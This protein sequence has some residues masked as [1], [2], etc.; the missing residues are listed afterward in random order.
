MIKD[1]GV[2]KALSERRGPLLHTLP[3]VT[4][5]QYRNILCEKFEIK[6]TQGNNHCMLDDG[7]VVEVLN[8]ATST[9]SNDNVLVGRKY[10]TKSN[11][12]EFPCASS[13][14]EVYK[15]V[16]RSTVTCWDTKRIVCKCIVVPCTD[17]FVCIPVLHTAR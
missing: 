8:I 6:L 5:P 16:G 2:K 15:I 3:G 11:F 7:S 17:F 13:S 10:L 9:D 4:L 14:L 1:Q 12:Y